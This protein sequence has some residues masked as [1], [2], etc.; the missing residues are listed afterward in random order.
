MF[1]TDTRIQAYIFSNFTNRD[2]VIANIVQQASKWGHKIKSTTSPADAAPL[3]PTLPRNAPVPDS[4][5]GSNSPNKERRR[6]IIGLPHELRK[7]IMLDD[8]EHQEK[9]KEKELE[10]KDKEKETDKQDKWK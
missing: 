6:S 4:W 2:G 5:V 9:H 7:S 10:R 1:D 3:I 8:M